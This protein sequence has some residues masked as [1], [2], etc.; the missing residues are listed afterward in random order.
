MTIRTRSVGGV[1]V[2][3]VDTEEVLV[4]GVQDALDCVATVRYEMGA[5]CVALRRPAIADD[6]FVLRTGMAGEVLQKFVNYQMKLAIIGDFDHVP[7]AA[8]RDFIRESNRG[9]HVF[10]VADEEEAMEKFVHVH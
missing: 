2:A 10:F 3:F 9:R 6:F 8:L 4:T 5:D 1:L 7:S